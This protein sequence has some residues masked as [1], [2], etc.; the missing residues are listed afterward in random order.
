MQNVADHGFR[1]ATSLAH[2]LH[3]DV[4]MNAN[5]IWPALV[6]LAA[7]SAAADDDEASAQQSATEASENA[8][9]PDGCIDLSHNRIPASERCLASAS[10]VYVCGAPVVAKRG[11]LDDVVLGQ[12]KGGQIRDGEYRLVALTQ[13]DQG[14]PAPYEVLRIRGHRIERVAASPSRFVP[15][16]DGRPGL[17]PAEWTS[18]FEVDGSVL[19]EKIECPYQL[20]TKAD[21]TVQGD[22][23]TLN[24]YY[25]RWPLRRVYRRVAD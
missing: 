25:S 23:L 7:C 10:S 4:D 17:Q 16:V 11:A 8:A 20:E 9:V 14:D 3:S 13:Y 19:T 21:Y 22:E 6:C 5:W 1:R 18:T 2:P 24:Q 12:G 15:A